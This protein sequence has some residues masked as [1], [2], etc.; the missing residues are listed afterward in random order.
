[1]TMGDL[2]VLEAIRL[3]IS[4]LFTGFMFFAAIVMWRNSS[5]MGELLRQG[6][7]DQKAREQALFEL[8]VTAAEL[9]VK[10]EAALR[11][12]D[13]QATALGE[14]MDRNAALTI[15]A[16]EA[17]ANAASVANS[18]NEKIADTNRRLSDKEE[19]T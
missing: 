6:R 5:I 10:T 18:L 14:K 16:A 3:V 8:K 19:K 12:T 13:K 15:K 1:M 2:S 4:L 17:S 11:A 9:A 7:E